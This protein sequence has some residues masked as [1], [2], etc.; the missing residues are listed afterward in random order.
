MNITPTGSKERRKCWGE[1]KQ[2]RLWK[3]GQYERKKEGRKGGGQKENG[4]TG[5]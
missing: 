1:V 5:K 3:N 4:K 2:K